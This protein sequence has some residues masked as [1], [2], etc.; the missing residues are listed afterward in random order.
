MNL[1]CLPTTYFPKNTYCTWTNPGSKLGHQIDHFIVKQADLRRVRNAGYFGLLGQY[2]DHAPV[3]ITLAINRQLKRDRLDRPPT[4][5][6][7][8]LLKDEGVSAAFNAAVKELYN[9]DALKPGESLIG[10]LESAMQQAA[11]Q[12]TSSARDQPGWYEAQKE[13][14]EPAVLARSHPHQPPNIKTKQKTSKNKHPHRPTIL[15]RAR[16]V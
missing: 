14:I 16:D 13:S 5:I 15:V 11:K 8:S 2:S 3:R 6:D 9:P 10:H 12:P 4:R 1:L 7:R